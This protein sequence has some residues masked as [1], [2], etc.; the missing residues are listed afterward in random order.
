[1]RCSVLCP[2]ET[3]CSEKR[4]K[5]TTRS[6]SFFYELRGAPSGDETLFR[7]KIVLAGEMKNAK[8]SSFSSDFRTIIKR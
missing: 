4:V 3:L 6:G 2:D 1:M 5:N 7:H 8:M